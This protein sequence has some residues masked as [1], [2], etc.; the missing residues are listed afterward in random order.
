MNAAKYT[1]IIPGAFETMTTGVIAAAEGKCPVTG[2]KLRL[3]FSFD[4]RWEFFTDGRLSAPFGED[5]KAF[6]D[7]SRAVIIGYLKSAKYLAAEAA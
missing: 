2:D 5:R 1:L 3:Q 4:R 6:H 7:E